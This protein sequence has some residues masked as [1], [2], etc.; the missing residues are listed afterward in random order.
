[1]EARIS[2]KGLE[3]EEDAI[4][5]EFR[6][7]NIEEALKDHGLRL[8]LP[9]H[10]GHLLVMLWRLSKICDYSIG[11]PHRGASFIMSWHKVF[12]SKNLNFD[13]SNPSIDLSW[14]TGVTLGSWMCHLG[15]RCTTYVKVCHFGCM[16]NHCV[17]MH[18]TIRRCV[19]P[20]TWHAILKHGTRSWC[21]GAPYMFLMS[22]GIPW[23]ATYAMMFISCSRLSNV[24]RELK[25]HKNYC[26]MRQH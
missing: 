24:S 12:F 21:K 14:K 3:V 9:S 11:V 15:S 18:H 22:H 25:M 13:P 1:M 10:R 20:C 16:I 5:L 8:Q 23:W 2:L 17:W 26:M 19:I 4:N 6:G 7:L